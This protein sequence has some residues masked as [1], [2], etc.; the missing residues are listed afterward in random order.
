[1][2]RLTA[3][4]AGFSRLVCG[5]FR[6]RAWCTGLS[7]PTVGVIPGAHRGALNAAIY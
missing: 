5:V 4:T 1:M 6:S 7:F 2:E 3:A